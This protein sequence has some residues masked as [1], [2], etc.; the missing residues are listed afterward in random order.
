[1]DQSKHFK[2]S[3]ARVCVL[4]IQHNPRLM[5]G[6]GVLLTQQNSIR[7]KLQ[8]EKAFRTTVVRD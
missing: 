7:N 6:C 8:L 4:E 1:M 2:E 5:T 3:P